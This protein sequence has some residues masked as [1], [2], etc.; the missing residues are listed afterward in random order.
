MVK[1]RLINQ[2]TRNTF[3]PNA[4]FHCMTGK[5]DR[6]WVID[7]FSSE[8]KTAGKTAS[9]FLPHEMQHSQYF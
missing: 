8:S 2:T 3:T 5:T 1:G 7:G 4:T 6:R 9:F